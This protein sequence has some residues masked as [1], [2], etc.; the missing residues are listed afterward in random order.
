MFGKTKG[1]Y[2]VFN[3]ESFYLTPCLKR[4]TVLSI[5]WLGF[6]GKGGFIFCRWLDGT[7]K[8]APR[9]DQRLQLIWQIHEELSQFEVRSTHSMLR[10]LYWWMDMQQEVATYVERCEVSNRVKLSFNTLIPQLRPLPIMDL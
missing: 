8:V 9:P 2:I 3:M 4:E 5:A 6:I 10:G 1:F 7:R